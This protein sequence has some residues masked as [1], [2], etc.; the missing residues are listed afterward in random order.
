MCHACLKRIFK[1]S[2]KDPAHMPP[3]CCTSDHIPLKHVDKLFDL[4]FKLKWNRKYQEYMTRNRIYCPARRCGEWIKPTQIH[5]ENGRKVGTCKRCQTR[6]C[7]QC[8]N[9]MH[10]SRDC[11]KDEATNQFIEKAK[12]E[13]WQRC[14]NCKAMVELKE[15]CNHMTC[16]CTAEFCMICGSKWKTCDCPWFNY[17]AVEADRLLDMNIPQARRAY[18]NG[19]GLAPLRYQEEI[20]RRREQERQDEALARRMA[21][22]ATDDDPAEDP[23]FLNIVG[24]GNAGE[25]HLNQHFRHR[26]RDLLSNNFRQAQ[27]EADAL[28]NGLV[29]G[30]ENPLPPGPFEIPP[31]MPNQSPA[32]LRRHH[33]TAGQNHNTPPTTRPNERVV[34]GRRMTHYGMEAGQN[35]PAAFGSQEMSPRGGNP[36]GAKPGVAR[37]VSARAAAPPPNE[38]NGVSRL[39]GRADPS[40]RETDGRIQNWMNGV[41]P[42]PDGV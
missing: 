29:T 16:R 28:L 23:P 10:K 20:D 7:C 25:H 17:N 24:I 3:K 33:T 37:R 14:F 18:A 4:K 42:T 34:P 35:L 27:R 38:T 22:M 5:L 39:I 32:G 6:V 26:A 15:G 1:M 31:L 19:E 9:K 8:N 2:V 30:R 41:V 40:R 13:G 36:T 11:P 12:A 21:A